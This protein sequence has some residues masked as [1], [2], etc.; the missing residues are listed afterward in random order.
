[1]SDLYNINDV[2]NKF[3]ELAMRDDL[4]EE[5][6]QEL[7][8]ALALELTNKSVNVIQFVRNSEA[9]T[10]A[11]DTEIARLQELKRVANNKLERFK[12]MLEYNMRELGIEQIDTPIGKISFRKCPKSVVIDDES[13]IP[14]E[15]K[16]TKT[17][18]TIDKKAIL[19]TFNENGEI[20]AGTRVVQNVKLS[21][22]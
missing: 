11:I 14:D 6:V 18:T 13:L 17:E 19:E 21:I 20:V 15:F 22:K 3:V 9:T 1:M 5:E 2:R 7:G 10:D 4:T 8:N 16:K 12:S